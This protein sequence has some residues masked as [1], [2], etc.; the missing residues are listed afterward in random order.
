MGGVFFLLGTYKIH[1]DA[2]GEKK[3]AFPPPQYKKREGGG[4]TKEKFF[5]RGKIPLNTLLC[6]GVSYQGRRLKKGRGYFLKIWKTA[7]NPK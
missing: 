1:N 5:F 3:R 6:L 7:G 2:G 4:R